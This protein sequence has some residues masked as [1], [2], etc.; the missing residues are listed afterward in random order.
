MGR[1]AGPF[2]EK[3]FGDKCKCSPLAIREKQVPGHYCLLHNLSYP[4]DKSSVNFNIPKEESTVHYSTIAE[5]IAVIRK[6]GK[7]CYIAKSDISDCFCLILLSPEIYHLMGFTWNEQ[8][9]DCCLPMGCSSSC[10]LFSI[11]IDAIVHILKERFGALYVINFW[12]I[13]FSLVS[14]EKNV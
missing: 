7:N 11:F 3:P 6:L 9:Y 10:C 14:P 13:S 4:Y 5:A 2:S 1:V 8:W 12:M